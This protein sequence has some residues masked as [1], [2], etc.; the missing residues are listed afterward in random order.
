MECE[1]NW[2]RVALRQPREVLERA[3]ELGKEI[4]ARVEARRVGAEAPPE[5]AREP[6]TE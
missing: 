5:P 2:M 6:P 3:V 4:E 1:E